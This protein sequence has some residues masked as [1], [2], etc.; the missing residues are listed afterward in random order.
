[1]D[2]LARS[3]RQAGMVPG[4]WLSPVAPNP[5]WD[6][7]GWLFPVSWYAKTRTGV[8]DWERL[9]P[10]NPDVA[11]FYYHFAAQYVPQRV[12]AISKSISITCR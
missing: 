2:S 7:G 10:T 6:R 5:G 4:V 9:D 1:M 12:T 8:P 11:A 3:I